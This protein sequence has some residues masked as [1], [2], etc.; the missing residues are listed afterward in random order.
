MFI[1]VCG[2]TSKKQIDWAI[3]LGYT[4]VGIVL[5]QPSVRYCNPGMARELADHAQ[6]KITVIA[7][8][9]DFKEVKDVYDN[10][11][12]IQIYSYEK[13]DRLILAG[14]EVPA[15]KEFSYFLYDMSRGSGEYHEPP[16]W[17]LDMRERLIISGGLNVK[18]VTDVIHR[19]EPYGIDVSSGVEKERGIKSYSL[20]KKFISEVNH[21]VR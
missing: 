3:E 20:M 4:A 10:F 5:H 14:T 19:F 12:Y 6:G 13:L 17:I 8:G 9:L 16:R 7:V 15:D 18:N 1:K 11:D 21:A 2:L